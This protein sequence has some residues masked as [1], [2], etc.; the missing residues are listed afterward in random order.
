MST[1]IV[2]PA[3]TPTMEE[4]VLV[5]WR[6]AKGD[7]IAQGQAIAEVETDKAV[8]EIESPASGVVEELLVREGAEGIAVGAVIATLRNDAG[9]GGGRARA[10]VGAQEQNP[11]LIHADATA[12][13]AARAPDA[14]V[15]AAGDRGERVRASPVARHLARQHGIDLTTICGTGPGKRI[16]KRDVESSI[17]EGGRDGSGAQTGADIVPMSS[18]RKTIARRMQ[19]SKQEAPHFYLT[20]DICTDALHETLSQLNEGAGQRHVTLTHLAIRAAAL[21][22]KRVPEVNVHYA[23]ARLVRFAHADVAVVVAVPGGLMTPVIRVAEDKS[24]TTIATEFASLMERARA[25]KLQPQEHTGGTFT[26]SNLGMY[27]IREFTA[28]ISPPQAAIVALGQSQ[29]RAVVRGGEVVVASML[30]ATLSGDHRAIDGVSGAGF[31][32]ELRRLLENPIS[33]LV[34]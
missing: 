32:G 23:N 1:P 33:L 26:I 2:L 3:L 29:A 19:L 6:V 34:Q 13:P 20:I 12:A 14:T 31:L 22:L 17:A 30:T 27:G 4:G 15:V 28:V 24:V 25:N 10:R 16:L 21:A 18:M 7:A 5:A 9:E 11:A 8:L